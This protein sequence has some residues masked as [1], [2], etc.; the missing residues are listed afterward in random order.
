MPD[1][2]T[3]LHYLSETGCMVFDPT[4]QGLV[5]PKTPTESYRFEIMYFGTSTHDKV[6][7]SDVK[8]D[9]RKLF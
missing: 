6:D 7:I 8:F 3:N 2:A 5:N 1:K 4:R 9:R